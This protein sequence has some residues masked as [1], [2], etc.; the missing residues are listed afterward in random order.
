MSI[1]TYFILVPALIASMYLHYKLKQNASQFVTLLL[2]GLWVASV[3]PEIIN[4]R[5][6]MNS[7]KTKSW[8]KV[9]VV[10]YA[11]MLFTTPLIAGL[12]ASCCVW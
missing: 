8:D 9:F 6:R 1:N 4:E 3:D 2:F 12:D 11:L 10:V 7:E 5:G